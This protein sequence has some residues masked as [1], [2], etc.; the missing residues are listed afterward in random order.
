MAR[1]RGALTP[2]VSAPDLPAQLESVRGLESRADLLGS[3]VVALDG[4]VDAA[5]SRL[6]ECAIAAASV[7]RLDLRGAMLTDVEI[8]TLR[9]TASR[10]GSPPAR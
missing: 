2:R 5:H 7:S 3:S 9:A 8:S 4:D 10:R 1:A 6:T